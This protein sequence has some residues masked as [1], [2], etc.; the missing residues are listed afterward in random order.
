MKKGRLSST[1]GSYNRCLFAPGEGQI[2][3]FEDIHTFASIPKG[4]GKLLDLD[5]IVHT[6]PSFIFSTLS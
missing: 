3:P 1:R 5:Q 2:D 4:L 6:M